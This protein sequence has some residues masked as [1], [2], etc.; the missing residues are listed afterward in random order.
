MDVWTWKWRN[1]YTQR[2]E[3][4]RQWLLARRQQSPE[5]K[6]LGGKFPRICT[7][8]PEMAEAIPNLRAIAIDR[9]ASD[10]ASSNNASWRLRLPMQFMVRVLRRVAAKRDADLLAYGVPTLRLKFTDIM[11]QPTE[12]VDGIIAFLHLTPTVQ[13]RQAAI[14]H[15]DP[16]L[17]HHTK[18]P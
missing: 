12:T 7:M 4:F 9:P 1:T 15:I 8:V 16:S 10:S 13:Q 14:D 6:T 2:V 17:N 18:L 5:A 11:T 3:L